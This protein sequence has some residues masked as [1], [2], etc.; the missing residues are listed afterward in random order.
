MKRVRC[1]LH[2]IIVPQVTVKQTY[3]PKPFIWFSHTSSLNFFSQSIAFRLQTGNSTKPEVSLPCFQLHMLAKF[4]KYTVQGPLSVVS[5]SSLIMK[6]SLKNSV[7]LYGDVARCSK[8]CSFWAGFKRF[9]AQ[10]KGQLG[11]RTYP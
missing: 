9:W 2:K 4:R 7:S 1:F 11:G 6:R 3:F 8:V 5:K 10:S